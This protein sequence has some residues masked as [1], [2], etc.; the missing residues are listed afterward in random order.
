MIMSYQKQEERL[1]M[2]VKNTA[3]AYIK[4][5]LKNETS[6][7]HFGAKEVAG[8]AL[9]KRKVRPVAGSSSVAPSVK[10]RH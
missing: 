8:I 9:R 2:E 1:C 7:R 5:G 6:A 3:Q 10:P 4:S